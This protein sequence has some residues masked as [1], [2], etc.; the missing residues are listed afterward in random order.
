MNV[1]KEN[2]RFYAYVEYKRNKKPK[3][4]YEALYEVFGDD[5]PGYSTVKRWIADYEKGKGD[6]LTEE[7]RSGRPVTAGGDNNADVINDLI[8]EDP[9]LSVRDLELETGLSSSTIHRILTNK[10]NYRFISSYWVPMILNSEQKQNRVK[11]ARTIR[12]TL[13]EM[14]PDRYDSYACEDETWVRFDIEHTSSSSKVWLP[15]GST[16]PQVASNK[17]TRRKCLVIIAF[18]ANKRISVKAL[19]YGENLNGEGYAAFIHETGEKWRKLRTHPITL[20]KLTWQDDNARPHIKQCVQRLFERRHIT[21]LHQSPYSPDFN[22]CDRWLND[23]I[24]KDLKKEVFNDAS[25]VEERVIQ[26]MRSIDEGCY[27]NEVDKLVSHC[28]KVIQ[29]GGEYITPS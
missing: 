29:T 10:L 24:K 3:E 25:E 17:L 18:T 1:T 4:I 6:L 27:R 22:L 19:P 14:G 16:R 9:H 21:H 28:S 26:L 15:A 5:A 13:L 8:D 2:C 7:L 20:D 11:A 23:F 12:D